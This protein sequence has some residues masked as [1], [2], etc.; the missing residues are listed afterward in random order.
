MNST[1]VGYF[2]AAANWCTCSWVRYTRGFG[3]F[4]GSFTPRAGLVTIR[5]SVTASSRMAASTPNARATVV[6]LLPFT[7]SSPLLSCATH[8]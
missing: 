5:R 4:F 8:S 7:L 1:S 3:V 6:A 2:D